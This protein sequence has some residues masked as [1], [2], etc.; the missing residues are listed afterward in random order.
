MSLAPA[1]SALVGYFYLNEVLGVWGIIGIFVTISGIALVVLQKGN[2]SETKKYIDK[3]GII[4]GVIAAF[5]QAVGLILSKKAFE[6]GELNSFYAALIRLAF[7]TVFLIPIVSKFKD[8]QNPI[9][10]IEK[11]Y[12]YKVYFL[13]L[14]GAI[15]GPVIGITLSLYSVAH[16]KVAV[17]SA[18][19]ATVPIILLPMV[20]FYYKENLNYKSVIGAMIAVLGVVILFV[21]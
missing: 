7:A 19:M 1:I 18:I 12:S 6:F 13:V 4:Y 20:K 11:G 15:F 17:A 5:G 14:A 21:R 8:F 2:P 10:L 9:K 3:R 16:A